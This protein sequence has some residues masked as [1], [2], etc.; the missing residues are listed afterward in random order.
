MLLD[1]PHPLMRG[2]TKQRNQDIP[3]EPQSD[4]LDKETQQLTSLTKSPVKSFDL[5]PS[6]LDHQSDIKE[7]KLFE[8]S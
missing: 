8:S 1:G 4:A 2:R 7:N 5:L 6:K 3:K